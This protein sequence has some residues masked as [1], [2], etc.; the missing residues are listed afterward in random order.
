MPDIRPGLRPAERE[1][2]RMAMLD[3]AGL[4]KLTEQDYFANV[5]RRRLAP[6]LD[7]FLPDAVFT[8]QSAF[9]SYRGRDSEIRGMF[10]RFFEYRSIL[11]ADLETIC[12]PAIQAVSSRFRVEL[13]DP[14]G[15]RIAMRSVNQWYVRDGRFARVYVWMSGANVL[16]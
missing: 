2:G 11:H 16:T 6:V 1:A 13:E 8:I 3:R 4:I 12:D 15:K 9:A 7:C 5:D 14:D 10:E